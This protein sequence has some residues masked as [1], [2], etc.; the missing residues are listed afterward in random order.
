M[1]R[2]EVLAKLLATAREA[3]EIVM[4]V[5]GEEDVGAELKGPNDPVTRADREANALIV[6][7]L[8]R[9]FPGIPIVAEE[10]DPSTYAD[11]GKAPCAFFVDP[12]DGTRDFI[13]R[14][15]E[16]CVMI[17]FTEAGVA[18]V[19]VVLCPVFQKT[20]TGIVG[21]GAF[22]NDRPISASKTS[23]LED[24]RCAVSRFHR[25]KSV[26]E[27]LARLACKELVP[28]GSAGIKGAYIASGELDV[29]AHPSRGAM[30]L[31]DSCAPCAIV[32]AAGG[33]LTDATGRPY[34]YRGPVAQGTGTLAASAALHAEAVRRLTA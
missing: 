13:E 26:D 21:V 28:V 14:D 9:D 27:K 23:K 3:S 8:A 4:R 30:K 20:Y 24:A 15:G 33:V 10:S 2:N 11:F 17:G 12:V 22:C 29:F 31:W 34:D 7:R 6:S 32:T 19:G 5:Y 18:T 25:S 16:F 1:D